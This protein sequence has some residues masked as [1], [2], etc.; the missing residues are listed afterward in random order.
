LRAHRQPNPED[1]MSATITFRNA[2]QGGQI[3]ESRSVLDGSAFR[4]TLLADRNVADY[5]ACQD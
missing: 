3:A 4:F 2:F 5:V 1:C